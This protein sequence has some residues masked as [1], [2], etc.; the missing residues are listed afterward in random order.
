MAA[1]M[2]KT[3]WAID[4]IGPS[5]Q[6]WIRRSPECWRLHGAITFPI[7]IVDADVPPTAA[8]RQLAKFA[9]IRN[10][11]AKKTA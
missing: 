9:V 8:G 10:R 5:G 11:A 2:M 1:E 4:G 6:P 7:L 3:C